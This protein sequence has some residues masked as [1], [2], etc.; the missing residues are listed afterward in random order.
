MPAR[1]SEADYRSL[2]SRHSD[3]KARPSKYNAKRCRL[4]GIGFSSQRERDR[5]ANLKL[6]ERSGTITGLRLQRRWPLVVNGRRIAVW[7]SDFDYHRDGRLVVEDCKGFRTRE[8]ILK[9]KLFE[10]LYGL[11]IQ[12]T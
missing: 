9:K 10:A 6:L 4:D 8:Y 12:E 11:A 3:R 7:V 1:I 2:S 5:Y